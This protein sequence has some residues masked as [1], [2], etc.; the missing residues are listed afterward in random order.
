MGYQTHNLF[1][2]NKMVNQLTANQISNK[3]ISVQFG[4]VIRCEISN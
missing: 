4:N 1:I 3:L 2:N